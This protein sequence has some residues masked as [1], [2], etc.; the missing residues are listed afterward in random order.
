ML[1]SILKIIVK[2]ENVAKK[3]LVENVVKRN[4]QYLYIVKKGAGQKTS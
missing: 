1:L 2:S 4:C 3:Y